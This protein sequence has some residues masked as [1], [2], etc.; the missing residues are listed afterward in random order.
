ML[1]QAAQQRYRHASA[2]PASPPAPA[3]TAGHDAALSCQPLF[4]CPAC[5]TVLKIL[6]Q[7]MLQFCSAAAAAAPSPTVAQDSMSTCTV[8]RQLYLLV[9]D[10]Q[11]PLSEADAMRL[12]STASL[13]LEPMPRLLRA[14]AGEAQLRRQGTGGAAAGL[15]DLPGLTWSSYSGGLELLADQVL[16]CLGL[17]SRVLALLLR[18]LAAATPP[19]RA[20]AAACAG[21]AL[22]QQALLYWLSTTTAGATYFCTLR[23]QYKMDC[24]VALRSTALASGCINQAEPPSVAAWQPTV[25]SVCALSL[26]PAGL[27]GRQ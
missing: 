18:S 14:A 25:I 15:Q 26:S 12:L 24:L 1:T 21:R 8:L 5:R 13:P 19:S 22:S 6:L 27:Q 23:G 10:I 3:A 2:E 16:S 17:S 11:A 9:I 4:L 7:P 20:L